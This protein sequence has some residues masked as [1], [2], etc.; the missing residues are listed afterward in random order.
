MPRVEITSA[1]SG[2]DTYEEPH[3]RMSGPWAEHELADG[4][5]HLIRAHKISKNKKFVAAIKKHHD[6]KTAEHE[7]TGRHMAA[8]VKTGRVSEK[9]AA[10]FSSDSAEKMHGNSPDGKRDVG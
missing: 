9:Q 5:H 1:D 7:E 6:K 8:L 10:R 3:E 2:R 4:A